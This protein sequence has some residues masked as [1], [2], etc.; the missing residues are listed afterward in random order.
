M[1]RVQKHREEGCAA[2]LGQQLP[3][4]GVTVGRRV[5]DAGIPETESR[6]APSFSRRPRRTPLQEQI[7]KQ[8]DFVLDF[9][10][11]ETV[12]KARLALYLYALMKTVAC[13]A[14]PLSS[15][16]CV[17]VGGVFVVAFMAFILVTALQSS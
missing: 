6:K 8:E 10:S 5:L 1:V 16:S 2:P 17:Q 15:A 4:T 3:L 9:W 14:Q 13:P 7:R 12:F 11:S